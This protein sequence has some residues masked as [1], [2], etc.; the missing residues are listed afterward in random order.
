MSP[1]CLI[2]HPSSSVELIRRVLVLTKY[3]MKLCA[4]SASG[5]L[6]HWPSWWIKR[7]KLA[8][9]LPSGW[10]TAKIILVQR[11]GKPPPDPNSYGPISLLPFAGK[12][13]EWLVCDKLNDVSWDTAEPPLTLWRSSRPMLL[14]SSW[15]KHQLSR[16]LLISKKPL[17]RCGLKGL[18]T[19]R[20][21]LL[22]LLQYSAL[23]LRQK[24][25]SESDLIKSLVNAASSDPFF[26][27]IETT[28][29]PSR[30]P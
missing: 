1:A 21:F 11:K 13:F 6:W 24:S 10:K 16:L 28:T 20:Q 7:T 5:S 23:I 3:Q 19:K 17:T 12:I 8:T 25:D 30:S 27:A 9:Y 29:W 14:L 15:P 26:D 18:F 22:L 4:G 2:Y